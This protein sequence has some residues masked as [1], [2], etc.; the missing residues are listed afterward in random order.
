MTKASL[1]HFLSGA[2]ALAFWVIGVFFIRFWRK[3]RDRFF[4]V[5]ACAFWV[6][7]AERVLLLVVSLE[8]EFRPYVYL[9]RLIAFLL[10]IGAIVDRNVRMHPPP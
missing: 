9:V 2:A 3:T 4:G 8:N 5:F 10:I 1:I 6:L 7:G